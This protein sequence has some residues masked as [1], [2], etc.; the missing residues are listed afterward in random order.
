MKKYFLYAGYYELIF[1]TKPL[2]KPYIFLSWHKSIKNAEKAAK[3]FDPDA[4]YVFENA[5]LR[6]E[7]FEEC[8]G[9]SPT[10]EDNLDIYPLLSA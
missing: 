9:Y 4:H 8:I 3:K 10:D 5:E 7:Y 6:A 2:D 1:S